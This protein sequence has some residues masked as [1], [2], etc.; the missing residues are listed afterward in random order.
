VEFVK[1]FAGFF[2]PST[3][4]GEYSEVRFL[5]DVVVGRNEALT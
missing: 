1:A 2:G 3:K 5:A 4:L